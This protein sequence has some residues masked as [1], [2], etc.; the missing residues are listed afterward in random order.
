MTP[1]S[2]SSVCGRTTLGYVSL[3]C[4]SPCTHPA[5]GE[6]ALEQADI[7]EGV[8]AR[9]NSWSQEPLAL[10]I[11]LWGAGGL[12]RAWRCPLADG[13]EPPLSADRGCTV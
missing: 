9:R 7:G 10:Q 4:F 11:S 3:T 8:Q 5:S 12:F 6:V 1:W 13:T 2:W